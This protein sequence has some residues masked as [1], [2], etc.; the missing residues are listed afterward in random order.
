MKKRY[1]ALIVALAIVAFSII[2]ICAQG[3]LQRSG[4]EPDLIVTEIKAY[5]NKTDCPAWFNLSNEI[6]VTVKNKGS[7][8]AKASKV[9]LY[10]DDEFFGRLPVS[11][12]AAGANE[13]VTFENWKPIGD[14]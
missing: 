11:R 5:H 12:L 3:D 13:A 1:I 7:T 10:I 4:E 6:D 8:P 9:S 2:P 14:E